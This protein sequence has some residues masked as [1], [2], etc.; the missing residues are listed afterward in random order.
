[1][2][3]DL[4]LVCEVLQGSGFRRMAAGGKDAPAG[5]RLL[6][7]EFQTDAAVRTGDQYIGHGYLPL[8]VSIPTANATPAGAARS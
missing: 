8:L 3:R 1:V 4:F 5:N 7:G 6:A 2:H